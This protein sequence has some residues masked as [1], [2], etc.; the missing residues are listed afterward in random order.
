MCLKRKAN[1]A[2]RGGLVRG[3]DK[4]SL[5]KAGKDGGRLILRKYDLSHFAKMG[6]KGG[7]VGKEKVLMVGYSVFAISTILML[8]LSS[9]DT[10]YAYILAAIF[11]LCL[12]ISETIQRAIIPRYVPSELRG[13]AYGQY[14]AVIGTNFLLPML[15]LDFYGITLVLLPPYHIV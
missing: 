14:N 5:S 9:E 4:E 3:I 12:G 11:G 7:K 2:R 15:C 13:T 1:I 6:K 10:L 8:V